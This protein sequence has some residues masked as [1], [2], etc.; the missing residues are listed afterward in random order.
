MPRGRGSPRRPVGV[1]RCAGRRGHLGEQVGDLSVGKQFD[2]VWIRPE[3]GSTLDVVLA[4]ADD[5][6]DALA[7]VFALGGSADVRGVW[8]GGDRLR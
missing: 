8:V 6:D 4:H 2:A 1:G 3:D 7:K 5:A